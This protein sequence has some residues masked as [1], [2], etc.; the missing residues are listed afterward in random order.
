[1]SLFL[2]NMR[3]TVWDG[4]NR[5]LFK[6]LDLN[7]YQPCRNVVRGKRTCTVDMCVALDV[8]EE[9]HFG[10]ID[11]KLIAQALQKKIFYVWQ[12]RFKYLVTEDF[13]PL[14]SRQPRLCQYS[15]QTNDNIRK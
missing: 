12:N 6:T 2:Y 3:D 7:N 1:M 11:R 5:T 14:N 8:Q 10:L 15:A 9:N 4:A 13:A